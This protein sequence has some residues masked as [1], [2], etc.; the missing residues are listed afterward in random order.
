MQQKANIIYFTGTGNSARVCGV[1]GGVFEDAGYEVSVIS[2]EDVKP[3]GV[4]EADLRV[5]AFPV[6][7]CSVPSVFIDWM[8]KLP[9][10]NG[11]KAALISVFG[12]LDVNEKIPG[13]DGQA[14]LQAKS[15]L[16][17]KGFDVFFG[18]GTG[19]PFN[20]PVSGGVPDE[21]KSKAIL[22]KADETIR[23]I[24]V[25]IVAGE[26]YFK[27]C[28]WFNEAW[29]KLFGLLYAAVGRR[30]I[31]KLYAA[32]DSCVKCGLCIKSCPVHTI[33]SKLGNIR[34]KWNCE[35][36]QRC[37][38]ICP[39]KSIN[40]TPARIIISLALSFMPWDS[41]II[42]LCNI[43]AAVNESGGAAIF[44]RLGFW[45]AGFV[46]AALA[47]DSVLFLL[48]STPGIGKLLRTGF[49]KKFARYTAPGFKPGK[50]YDN[51]KKS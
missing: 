3:D 16:E 36:C 49:M 18:D 46:G 42:S 41:W 7:A 12:S 35:G 9:R 29:S 48:E 30:W 40:L 24:G 20:V 5:F 17:D 38:N 26:K 31:G 27:K 8:R 22:E 50:S 33:N 1:L 39:K 14:L 44:L 34:W 6:Y 51:R 23:N 21:E 4:G 47:A 13:Y 11:A 45:A 28:S 2:I 37:V 32:D 19:Y 15:L 10:N 25:R 43:N